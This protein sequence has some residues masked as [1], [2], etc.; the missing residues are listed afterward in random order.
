MPDFIVI[1][2]M[3]NY[4]AL[5]TYFIDLRD[6]KK[7]SFVYRD[8]V[9]LQKIAETN[10]V[11][12]KN[13][14]PIL[15]EKAYE[16][17]WDIGKI[18]KNICSADVKEAL[19]TIKTFE[20]LFNNEEVMTDIILYQDIVYNTLINNETLCV[21]MA[22]NDNF[23]NIIVKENLWEKIFSNKIFIDKNYFVNFIITTPNF[24]NSLSDGVYK[25][26][27]KI[28][29]RYFTICFNNIEFRT[30]ILEKE[31]VDYNNWEVMKEF[32]YCEDSYRVTGN[33]SVNLFTYLDC[34]RF[35]LR[36]LNCVN[37]NYMNI[38][39]TGTGSFNPAYIRN[40]LVSVNGEISNLTVTNS[41]NYPEYTTP[42]NIERVFGY[43]N[44]PLTNANANTK[45]WLQNDADTSYL[46][47]WFAPCEITL[48]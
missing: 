45:I 46:F 10:F 25:R 9:L 5:L 40:M 39:Y 16:C 33:N 29:K 12:E 28:D 4:N 11:N 19:T 14:Q 27:E 41:T 8:N 13:V 30:K 15:F 37:K 32:F 6:N 31:K 1:D 18:F 3:Q 44:I 34:L 47:R 48:N 7:D 21:L 42:A 23:H 20:E 17:K 35:T 26:L 24:V 43:V 22:T 36:P 38:K 2:E